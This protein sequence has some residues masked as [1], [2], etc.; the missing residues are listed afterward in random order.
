GLATFGHGDAVGAGCRLGWTVVPLSLEPPQAA[1]STSVTSTGAR[2]F[3]VSR[4]YGDQRAWK[5]GLVSSPW[6]APRATAPLD[7]VVALPGSKSQTNRVLVLAA[8]A[9]GRSV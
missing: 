9:G 7:A 2:R 6:S 4:G 1:V 5:D 3:I 8:L